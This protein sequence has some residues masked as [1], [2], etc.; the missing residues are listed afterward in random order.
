MLLDCGEFLRL[1]FNP[2]C[3]G[4][5]LCSFLTVPVLLSCSV[6]KH[7]YLACTR[8]P[9]SPRHPPPS[10][11]AGK[12]EVQ[13]NNS[14]CKIC[15]SVIGCIFV[16][17]HFYFLEKK[18]KNLLSPLNFVHAV[19]M[20][21]VVFRANFIDALQQLPDLSLCKGSFRC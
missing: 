16:L 8:P 20:A 7:V 11:P 5:Q 10:V 2:P 13:T 19:L 1:R 12:D 21:C 17:Y 6:L 14:C 4:A 3:A 9:S 15:C 18:N